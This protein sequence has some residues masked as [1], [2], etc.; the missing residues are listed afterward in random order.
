MVTPTA[1]GAQQRTAVRHQ[2]GNADGD[3]RSAQPG[4]LTHQPGHLARHPLRVTRGD[5][6]QRAKDAL[7]QVRFKEQL[8]E[9]RR[10]E[11]SNATLST[12]C[13]ASSSA[14][15]FDGTMAQHAGAVA[16]AHH[17]PIQRPHDV[18]AGVDALQL[19]YGIEGD[20]LGRDCFHLAGGGDDG[21]LGQRE[22][23][24][25]AGVNEDRF[26]H[27]VHALAARCPTRSNG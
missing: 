10:T 15:E 14:G 5:G 24:V 1:V 4:V 12:P 2:N 23:A 6:L 22:V 20:I 27:A 17:R 3:G 9:T 8:G 7:E 21:E 11:I 26:Q 19:A 16:R 18:A 25:L 13:S